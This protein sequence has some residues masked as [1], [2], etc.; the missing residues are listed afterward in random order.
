MRSDSDL[1]RGPGLVAACFAAATLS[2]ACGG[3]SGPGPGVS[4]QLAVAVTVTTTDD[5]RFVVDR[6][7]PFRSAGF[8]RLVPANWP[9]EAGELPTLGYAELEDRGDVAEV[10]PWAMVQIASLDDVRALP[11]DAPGALPDTKLL[12]SIGEDDDGVLTLDAG[13]VHGVSPGDLYF[14]A[15]RERDPDD[16]RLG[17]RFG[18]LLRVV[19][20]RDKDSTARVEHADTPPVPGDFAIFGQANLDLP[21]TTATI[22]VAPF[23]PDIVA[24]TG[25]FPEIAE[26][27]PECLARYGLTNI[28]VAALDGFVDPSPTDAP[29][30]AA[31]AAD[32]EEGFGA[33]V[34]GE[35]R[36]DEFLFNTT[37]WGTPPHPAT[38]VGILAG[39]LPLPVRSTVADLGRQLVPSFV[40]TAL[41]LRGEDAMAIYFLESVLRNDP[42]EPS[43]R[44]HLR[45]HLALRY[46]SI[47][48]ATSALR[49]MDLDVER[50]RRAGLVFPL[51]NALSIRAYLD[52]ETG[53]VDQW[54]S[55]TTEFLEVAEGVLPEAAL[56]RERLHRARALDY[57]GDSEGALAVIE[58]VRERAERLEDADLTY[59]A[60]IDLAITTARDDRLMALLVLAGLDPVFDTLSPEEQ[61]MILLLSAELYAGSEEPGAALEDLEASLELTADLDSPPFRAG[62]YRRASAVYQAIGR[63]VES[64]AALEETA[65]LYLDSAQLDSASTTLIRLAILQ[66]EVS[67]DLPRNVALEAVGRARRNLQLG[68]EL[69]LR[70]GN[71]LE[72]SRGLMLAGFLDTQLNQ[73][74]SAEGFLDR[75][76]RLALLSANY[77]TLFDL[78]HERSRLAAERGD[79]A[80]AQARQERALMWAR[81]GDIEADIEPI[82]SP[83]H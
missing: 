27:L 3:A 79:Y 65:R 10:E 57:A 32:D 55:D 47:G 50:S 11:A 64:V 42:L 19:D 22:L 6:S 23:A 28:A 31:E 38:T 52:Y 16:A 35:V 24:E 51:L 14:V 71:S 12:V 36:G 58:S 26:A 5:G 34:F 15:N 7:G 29:E 17:T 81:A 68:A 9:D 54:V 25:S 77:V 1:G 82:V 80:E 76:E 69:S 37:T 53:L 78:D 30:T 83:A 74:L 21:S 33:V 67:S 20:V 45:E 2:I 56:Q 13:E 41:A 62:V 18:A 40:A 61:T 46:E 63:P 75:A 66:L 60:M 49:V 70:L 48:R 72:A 59:A 44:F 43:V 8:A 4:E 39:G 73:A